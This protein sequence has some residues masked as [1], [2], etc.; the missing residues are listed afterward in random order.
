MKNNSSSVIDLVII[1]NDLID[2]FANFKVYQND[3]LSDHFPLSASFHIKTSYIKNPN[4][5]Y[6]KKV[7][8]SLYTEKLDE[9][10]K[11]RTVRVEMEH[12]YNHFIESIKAAEI[13]SVEIKTKK[14]DCKTLPNYLLELINSRKVIVKNMRKAK[15]NFKFKTQY[16]FLT[17]LI[18]NE[19]KA[20]RE[21]LWTKF[22]N[23]IDT[24]RKNSKEYL[25]KIKFIGQLECKKKSRGK[26]KIPNLIQNDI[27]ACS[28]LEK[29][30]LFGSNLEK[31]FSNED[32]AFDVETYK[33]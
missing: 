10:L 19:L 13:A 24:T 1:T 29:A 8:W 17:K 5:I 3:M 18:K 9:E 20:F 14:V 21:C 4:T 25:D 16:N 28:N 26:K 15:S 31:I 7:N 27:T 30:Q 2:K 11:K 23:S 6:N 12:D 32:I 22:C 33:I